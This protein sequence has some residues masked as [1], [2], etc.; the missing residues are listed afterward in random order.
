M[1][2]QLEVAKTKYKSFF[3]VFLFGRVKGRLPPAAQSSSLRG[4]FKAI[5]IWLLSVCM[6]ENSTEAF[7]CALWLITTP[8]TRRFFARSNVDIGVFDS[9]RGLKNFSKQ[10]CV[11]CQELGC[12]LV[13]VCLLGSLIC[14]GI[15]PDPELVSQL[16]HSH[17]RVSKL[18]PDL[19]WDG[20]C[21]HWSKSGS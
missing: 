13:L 19:V 11:F 10:K 20:S 3:P 2:E 4:R 16:F 8:P 17:C 15:D 7:S 12:F 6:Q 21:K 5:S 1:R 9:D 14:L 18:I